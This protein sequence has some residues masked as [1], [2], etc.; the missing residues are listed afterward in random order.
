MGY[1]WVLLFGFF[2]M[3]VSGGGFWVFI[4]AIIG[5]IVY[6]CAVQT[7]RENAQLLWKAEVD[8]LT[9]IMND[10]TYYDKTCGTWK[11]KEPAEENEKRFN[12]AYAARQQLY[13]LACEGKVVN[14][15]R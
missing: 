15:R 11:F 6:Y 14:K 3:F 12:A 4:L 9:R 5:C 13:K 1:F 2:G 8:G 7:P 10:C